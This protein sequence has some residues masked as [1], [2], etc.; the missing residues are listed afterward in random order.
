MATRKAAAQVAAF[1]NRVSYE[2]LN[3]DHEIRP[4]TAIVILLNETGSDIAWH[5]HLSWPNI[6]DARQE[7]ER[8]HWNARDWWQAKRAAEAAGRTFDGKIDNWRPGARQ[9]RLERDRLEQR[10]R[11]VRHEQTP[12]VCGCEKRFK[13][14]RGLEQ[15]KPWCDAPRK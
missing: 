9:V 10:M 7:M 5:G 1:L 13:S 4:T 15:H 3:D 12:F 14:A 2:V 6:M 11:T 8:G